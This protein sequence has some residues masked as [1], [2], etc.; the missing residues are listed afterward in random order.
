MSQIKE[1]IAYDGNEIYELKDEYLEGSVQVSLKREGERSLKITPS[2]IG[3]RFI[4]LDIPEDTP[5]N[6]VLEVTY[7]VKQPVLKRFDLDR[8]NEAERKIAALEAVVSEQQKAL[9]N[10]LSIKTFNT[11]M[12]M[13]EQKLGVE[14]IPN[15]AQHPYPR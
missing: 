5:F 4:S 2:E 12:R 10:R 15:T 7:K 9:R 1:F 3:S 8:L 14:I 13:I 11:W 6:S